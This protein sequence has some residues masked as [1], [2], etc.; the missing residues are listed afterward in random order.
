V[1]VGLIALSYILGVQVGKAS[2]NLR[3]PEARS[4]DEQLKAMPEPLL[5]QLKHFHPTQPGPAPAPAAPP[6]EAAPAPPKPEAKAEPKTDAKTD[7][8]ADGK[9]AA[10]SEP[11]PEA[12]ERWTLQLVATP[13]KAEAE[14]VAARAK[15]AGFPAR[16]V[17]EDKAWKVRLTRAAP[18][19]AA[20]AAA[21]KLRA[22]GFKPFAVKAE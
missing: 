21:E 7:A 1:G 2:A 6:L 19:E 3:R 17:L 14:R 4:V 9:A 11:A 15:A 5:E 13:Q 22:A 18:K 8:K 10:K 12:G 20:D 16:V